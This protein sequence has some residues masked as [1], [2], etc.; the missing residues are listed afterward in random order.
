MRW[1]CGAAAVN[2]TTAQNSLLE[3]KALSVD[4]IPFCI[5]WGLLLASRLFIIILFGE[6]VETNSFM[7]MKR[8]INPTA[9]FSKNPNK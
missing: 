5:G 4:D 1:W 2:S 6:I 9:Y 8:A 3:T 7:R